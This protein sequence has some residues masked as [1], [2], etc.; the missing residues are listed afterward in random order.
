MT[1]HRIRGLAPIDARRKRP[2]E[3]PES[4][5]AGTHE[6]RYLYTMETTRAESLEPTTSRNRQ[7]QTTTN[8]G[9]D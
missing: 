2:D 4:M 9:T 1:Y 8:F 3:R 6:R 7:T 5:N